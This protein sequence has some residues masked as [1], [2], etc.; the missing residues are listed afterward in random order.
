ME[1][2]EAAALALRM[3]KHFG[4]KVA[5]ERREGV[6]HVAIPAGRFELDPTGDG[7]E[8]R[9][10]PADPAQLPRLQEVVASHLERFARTPIAIAWES[11]LNG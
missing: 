2:P 4:H 6:V 8:I 10:H 9:L 3:E 1:T 7:L 11:P 5:V